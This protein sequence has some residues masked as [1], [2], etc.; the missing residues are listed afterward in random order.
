MNEIKKRTE[1][2]KEAAELSKKVDAE[3]RRNKRLEGYLKRDIERGCD[4]AKSASDLKYSSKNLE[5]LDRER[6]RALDKLK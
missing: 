6:Q 3:K 5:K 4:T 1:A 2:A